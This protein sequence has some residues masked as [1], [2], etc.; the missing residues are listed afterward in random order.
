MESRDEQ[1]QLVK[2]KYQSKGD[3]K[4]KVQQAI[5][6]KDEQSRLIKLR[7]EK[8]AQHADEDQSSASG[9][10]FQIKPPKGT[11]DLYPEQMAVRRKVIDTI[12]SIFRKHGA[13]EI[14]TPVF[15]LK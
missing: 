2:F 15:E 14:D 3:A 12:S 7:Y 6:A 10:S 5:D 13:V 9:P 8:K 1:S 4:Q 11:R